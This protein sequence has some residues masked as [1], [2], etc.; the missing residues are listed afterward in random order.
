MAALYEVYKVDQRNGNKK[1]LGD[2]VATSSKIAWDKFK[3][4]EGWK[5]RSLKGKFLVIPQKVRAKYTIVKR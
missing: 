4:E 3:K 5:H 2:V 1:R